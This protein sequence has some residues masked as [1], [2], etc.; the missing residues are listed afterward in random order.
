MQGIE[1]PHS[2]PLSPFFRVSSVAEKSLHGA[3]ILIVTSTV[4][5]F[6]GNQQFAAPLCSYWFSWCLCASVVDIP[7]PNTGPGTPRSSFGIA[8]PVRKSA[9]PL[10]F[11]FYLGYLQARKKRDQDE[12]PHHLIHVGVLGKAQG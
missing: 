12:R 9:S 11:L 5:Q 3:Q 6:S 8:V 4:G 7:G 1:C 2:P 10:R